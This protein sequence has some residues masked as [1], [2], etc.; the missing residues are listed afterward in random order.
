MSWDTDWSTGVSET[1]TEIQ[2]IASNQTTDETNISTLQTEVAALQAAAPFLATTTGTTLSVSSTAE[3]KFLKV[4][5]SGVVAGGVSTSVSA[6]I[7]GGSVIV[8]GFNTNSSGL[9]ILE[10]D[11]YFD[12]SH[13][14]ALKSGSNP[15]VAS[16]SSTSFNIVLSSGGGAITVSNFE[17]VGF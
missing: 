4:Y 9:F 1:I 12:G 10:F 16:N 3:G 7:G 6:N 17:A 11:M 13:L 8:S 14:F 5:A 15:Q 2:T